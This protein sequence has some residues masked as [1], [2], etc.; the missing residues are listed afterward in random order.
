VR[1]QCPREPEGLA[2]A[3][4]IRAKNEDTLEEGRPG[5]LD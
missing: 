2:S 1:T 4:R 5:M 3:M